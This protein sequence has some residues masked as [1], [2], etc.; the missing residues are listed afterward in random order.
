M[1]K[2][3]VDESVD[4]ETLEKVATAGCP[5]CG[6]AVARNGNVLMCPRCGSEPFEET[7][8]AWQKQR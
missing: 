3:A 2:Y 1:E 5:Q 4:T 8:A 7:K 6:S